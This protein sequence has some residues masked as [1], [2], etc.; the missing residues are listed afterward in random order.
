MLMDSDMKLILNLLTRRSMPLLLM[1]A[2]ATLMP[3]TAIAK[4]ERPV[5]D[6]NVSLPHSILR[7]P[8]VHPGREELYNYAM[9]LLSEALDATASE[10]GTYELLVKERE[11][12]QSRQLRGLE[13][14]FLDVTWTMTSKERERQYL[15]VRVP[16]MA[17]LLGKR[18]LLVKEN[19]DRLKNVADKQALKAFR[20]VQGYDWPDTKIFRASDIEVLETTYHASFRI[21][22]EGFADIFPRSVIE[23]G[24]ELSNAHLT[25]GL[26]VDEHIIISYPSPIFFFVK[27]DNAT[28]ATRL[29]KGLLILFETGRFQVLLNDYKGYK[30]SMALV[31]SRK[32]IEIE[33][34]LLS[35]ES[36]KALD[37][38]LPE[39]YSRQ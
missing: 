29:S 20:V 6:N 30:E 36:K 8:N 7:L 33:N 31:N 3:F 18:A 22:T 23:V 9:N 38:F 5:L 17:G 32:V 39:L 14:G 24:E 21:V 4:R 27:S 19:D 10:Y 25:A 35:E 1:I 12:S 15:P 28:L 34:P 13:H 2:M 16:I 11:L 26:K 37:R